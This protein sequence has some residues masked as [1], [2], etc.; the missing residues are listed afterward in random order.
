LSE[1]EQ[2]R[3]KEKK[4]TKEIVFETMLHNTFYLTI[5]KTLKSL[6]FFLPLPW[7]RYNL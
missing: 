1:K 6:K 7:P 3:T 4:K 5:S 2:Q